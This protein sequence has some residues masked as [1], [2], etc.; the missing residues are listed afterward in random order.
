MTKVW[1]PIIIHGTCG[2]LGLA[3]LCCAASVVLLSG[4]SHSSNPTTVSSSSSTSTGAYTQSGGS[5]TVSGKSYTATATDES[6]VLVSDGGVLSLSNSTV[7]TSGNTS[8]ADSSSF[9]GLN[10]GVLATS[11]S[12]M[13]LTGCSITTTG[14]GAN[15]VFSTGSGT[16]IVLTNDTITC[17]GQLG[18]G[19]DATV[20]GKMT[21]TNVVITTSSTNAAAIATDRGGGTITATGGTMKTSGSDSPGIYSTG[22]ITVCGA[23]ITATGSEGVVIEGANNATLTNTALTGGKGS[24]NRG[25]LIYQSTS[26]DASGD[27]GTLTL[28]GGSF[29]W[30]AS[31]PAFYVT[32]S[33]GVIT[34]TGVTVNNSSDTLMEASANQWGTSGEN[35]GTIIFTASGVAMTGGVYCDDLSSITLTMANNSSLSGVINAAA[36]S[37]DATS[38][39][40]VTGTSHLT[41]LSNAGGISGT[42]ITNITG[43]G[44]TVYYDSTLSANSTLGGVTFS[45]NGGGY[46]IPQ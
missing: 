37:L 29:T 12:T 8:S 13:T 17:S 45:L 43:N 2:R 44:Y 35:G 41:S 7:T 5:A 42:S 38:T 22:T 25:V 26:G 15:G 34:L 16:S 11:A 28:T 24:R 23:T 1:P 9:Y 36:L 32:N 21:L 3:V 39:W 6:G 46:L 31:G 14:T 18:H 10:A 33:T 30:P 20:A 40:N 19:V 27:E 4:C